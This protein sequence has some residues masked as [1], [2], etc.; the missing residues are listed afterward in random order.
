MIQQL[1]Y[2]EPPP[3]EARRDNPGSD[4]RCG[5][6]FSTELVFPDGLVDYINEQERQRN[7]KKQRRLAK[8]D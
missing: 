3:L 4:G 7:E 5:I 1:E 2:K 6:S 8:K